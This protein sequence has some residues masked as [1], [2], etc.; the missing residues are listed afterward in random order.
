MT[1]NQTIV[2]QTGAEGTAGD[3]ERIHR[4]EQGN[5]TY[6]FY[7]HF[8]LILLKDNQLYSPFHG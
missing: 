5:E 7:I 3:K 4:L 8:I 6:R 1:A 2:S